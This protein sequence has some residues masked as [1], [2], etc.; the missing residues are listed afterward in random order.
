MELNLQSSVQYVPR[1]GPMLAKKL[2]KLGIGTVEDLIR[3]APFRYN[4]FSITSP[5]ARI[6]PGETVTAAGIVESIRNAFTKNGKKLQEMRISDVSGTL[7]VVWFNQMYL[8]KIIHPGDTIHVAGQ[9]NWFGRKLVMLSPEYEVLN[10][11]IK[12]YLHTGRLVPVYPETSGI[13]SKWLRA[14]IAYALGKA[15]NQLVEYLPHEII[16]REHLPGIR[17]SIRQ[18]HFPDNRELAA[19]ARERLALE[20]LLL[21]ILRAHD[22]KRSWQQSQVAKKLTIQNTETGRFVS[23]LPFTLTD[24]QKNATKEI[25]SDITKNIPMNRILVGD[26]GSGKTVVAAIAIYATY[27]NNLRSVIMAPTQ[28][29]ALQHFRTLTSLLAPFGI[30]TFLITGGSPKKIDPADVYVGT[31]A[32]L[33]HKAQFTRVGLVIIDEQQRFG[34]EQ[35]RLL[36]SKNKSK[37]VPHFL[38][39][40]AT[41]IPR[42]MA[43]T[44]YGNLDLSVLTQMPLGRKLVKTWVVPLYKRESAYRW[45]E[46]QILSEESGAFIVCPFI[47]QSESLSTVRAAKTEFKRLRSEV[48]P[49]LQLGLLHGRLKTNEKHQI[50]DHFRNRKLDIVVTTPVVE[51]GIDI[52]NATI[53]LIEGADRFG[54]A[55]LHQLRGRVGRGTKPSYCLLFT[56]S[57]IDKT[58][59]RLRTLETVHNGPQLAEIDLKLRGPGEIFGTKQHGIPL[60]RIASLGDSKLIAKA[61]LNAQSLIS[62]DADLHQFPLLR[63]KL[64]ESKIESVQD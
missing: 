27:K 9:I 41:P 18:I 16:T 20:E 62:Q 15:G 44:L 48:F 46:K 6:Q 32:L 47:E 10:L 8:P 56:E 53:M 63:A 21:L 12:D 39:M 23:S 34:V 14:R 51:V 26:V 5:I 2:A 1:V 4:D 60:L 22:Q 40:T 49:S 31:H 36:E 59:E 45:I 52:P 7:D 28:I 29:L 24:D 17:E 19:R 64:K 58:I 3:Y 55:Q 33:A 37:Y 25:L 35:R 43:K 61:Q 30:K 57:T 13:T 11:Q 42:T 50:L 54:L 38:T